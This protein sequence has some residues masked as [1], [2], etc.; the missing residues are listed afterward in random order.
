MFA[1]LSVV[2]CGTHLLKPQ[3][4]S[5]AKSLQSS[6][7]LCDP[8]DCSLPGSS[9]HGILQAR[10]LEWGAIAFSES[11][12]RDLKKKVMPSNNKHT[13]SQHLLGMDLH[14]EVEDKSNNNM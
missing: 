14:P 11:T 3:S 8:M 12:S 10:V 2:C 1:V 5:A 4:T 9:V 7:T 13:P 6:P